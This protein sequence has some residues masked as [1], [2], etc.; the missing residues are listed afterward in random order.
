MVT[1]SGYMGNHF[2]GRFWT[3]FSVVKIS[4]YLFNFII[5]Y[6]ISNYYSLFE[7]WSFTVGSN[8]F[9]ICVLDFGYIQFCSLYLYICCL[10]IFLF[11]K[12]WAFMIMS[13]LIYLSAF[14]KL[15]VY[16]PV[17][18]NCYGMIYFT[19]FLNFVN[20]CVACYIVYCLI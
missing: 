4:R 9:Y 8:T 16:F 6:F 19:Y 18:L 2:K 11:F 13:P 12:F 10:L 1:N 17:T 15:P 5:L 7:V 20:L 3:C 14:N